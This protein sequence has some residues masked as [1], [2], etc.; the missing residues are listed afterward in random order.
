MFTDMATT[1]RQPRKYQKIRRAEQQAETRQRIVEAMVALHREV[2]PA[3][4]TISAIAERAGVERLTVYR[5]FPD[6]RSMFEAC[7]THYATEVPQPDPASWADIDDP[8]ERLRAVLLTFYEYY[9]R[10]E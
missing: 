10:A 9:R 7:T 4:A 1:K 5:H 2:G 3:R 8:A 6:E